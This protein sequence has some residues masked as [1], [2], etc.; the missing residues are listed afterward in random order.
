MFKTGT[1]TGLCGVLMALCIN[2]QAEP[3]DTQTPP[4]IV[5]DQL[6]EQKMHVWPD[7]TRYEGDWQ[8]GQPHGLGTMTYNNGAMYW[9]RFEQGRRNGQGIMKY[10]NGDEYEGLWR[11]DQPHGK[12]TLHYI[13]GDVYAGAFREGK[14]QGEGKQ[15]YLDGT[16]YDGTW[17]NDKPN[18]YGELTFVSGGLYQGAFKHGKP[19][20]YG[21]YHYPN[22]DVYSGNWY[23]GNQNGS[24]RIEYSAG[25]YYTGEFVDGMRDGQGVLVSAAG[26]RYEGPFRD[27][28]AHGEGNCSNGDEVKP[29]QYRRNERLAT[30]IQ[31]ASNT[32]PATI[33]PQPVATPSESAPPR[34]AAAPAPKPVVAKPEPQVALV[35][36]AKP[37]VPDTPT[38]PKVI[39]SQ[40]M[41][42][43]ELA[44]QPVSDTTLASNATHIAAPAA[45]PAATPAAASSTRAKPA[46]APADS[47]IE[48]KV[49]AKVSATFVATLEQ[50]KQKLQHRTIADLRRDRSDMYFT[51]NWEGK[52]LMAIPLK[53]WWQKR[54]SLLSDS[55]YIVSIHGD[56]EIRMVIEDYKGPGK[57]PV[58][59]ISVTSAEDNLKADEVQ[60]GQIVVTSEGRNW[61]TGSF[62]F[63]VSDDRGHQLA[64]DNGAFRLS[65]RD[66][67]TYL[68]Q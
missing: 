59:Q 40:E 21:T 68:R 61:I 6:T 25:G 54:S 3:A 52:D 5:S 11:H 10:A 66:S 26:D 16:Y 36:V 38:A 41:D 39:P 57:Y 37:F 62:H 56:T 1:R 17:A 67:I 28:D 19:H 2:I 58:K 14:K 50:E 35:P 12:G 51:D 65:N 47:P 24:G 48:P 31:I 8:R 34:L 46:T 22:G 33:V 45:T 13:N 49:K 53:A 60:S 18:G 4:T 20:G 9:G 15:V 7:G 29:C 30:P 55:L 43:L 63:A 44:T 64:F 27:N 32:V 23:N 42:T